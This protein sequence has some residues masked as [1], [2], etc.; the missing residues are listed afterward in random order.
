MPLKSQKERAYLW[1]N[2]PDVARKMEADTPKGTKL[3]RYA[4]KPKKK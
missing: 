1:A 2:K 3:P 4:P